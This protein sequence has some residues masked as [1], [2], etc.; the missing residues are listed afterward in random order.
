VSKYPNNLVV[1]RYSELKI[2]HIIKKYKIKKDKLKHYAK[3][4]WDIIDSFN[5]FN[6]TFVPR[7]KNK[8]TYSLVV[9]TSHFKT[10]DS[11]NPNNFHV[12]IVFRP[13][14]PHN[15]EYWKVF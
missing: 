2:N 6:I 15:Q 4:V 3:K 8:K 5:S 11:Q 10:Y 1:T 7:E 12:K 9:A 14:I 13:S